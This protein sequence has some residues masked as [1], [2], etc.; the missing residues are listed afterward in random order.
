M[1]RSA[2]SRR[3]GERG[4][5]GEYVVRALGAHRAESRFHQ[6]VL[7]EVPPRPVG[8]RELAV[9]PLV[10]VLEGVRHAFLER[11]RRTHGEEI[12]HFADRVGDVRG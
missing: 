2:R 7:Q 11:R 4:E 8:G 12:V 6:R 10:E 3:L 9:E 1:R 5:I